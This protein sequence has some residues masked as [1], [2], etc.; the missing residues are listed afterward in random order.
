MEIK[1]FPTTYYCYNC[2]GMTS[3]V[4]DSKINGR[5]CKKCLDCGAYL[6]VV[7]EP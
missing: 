1:Q 7:N 2:G 4:E 3:N 5:S 6:E